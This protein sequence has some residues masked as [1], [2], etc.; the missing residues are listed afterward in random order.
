MIRGEHGIQC[1]SC[2]NRIIIQM[3]P[4]IHTMEK[5]EFLNFQIDLIFNYLLIAR[6]L[7]ALLRIFIRS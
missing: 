3:Q 5:F 1:V 4:E 7:G 2:C 6:K